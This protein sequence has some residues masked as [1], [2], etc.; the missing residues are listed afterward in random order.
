MIFTQPL[1]LS[2]ENAQKFIY[3]TGWSVYTSISLL[4]GEEDPEGLSNVGELLKRKADEGVRVLI[5]IWNEKMS[6]FGNEGGVLGTHD[7]ETKNYIRNTSENATNSTAHAKKHLC[8]LDSVWP[9]YWLYFTSWSFNLFVLS[10]LFDTSLVC[11]RFFQEHKND[12]QSTA[13]LLR[14]DEFKVSSVV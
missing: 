14:P 3:I 1:F 7:E 11:Y 2:I 13:E 10:V 12:K 6:F 4:R 8:E 9:Y 5:L